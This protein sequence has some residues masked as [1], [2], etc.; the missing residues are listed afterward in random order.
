MA[1]FGILATVRIYEISSTLTPS[2]S[3]LPVEISRENLELARR[4]GGLRLLL[5]E[6]HPIFGDFRDS[7]HFEILRDFVDTNPHTQLGIFEIST[8]KLNLARAP[9]RLSLVS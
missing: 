4:P 9:G 8:I 6:T 5:W 1:D 2:Y 3:R 7:G